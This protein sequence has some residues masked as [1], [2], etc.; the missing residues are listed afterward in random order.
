MITSAVVATIS[1]T[2]VTFNC[3]S[4]YH[5]ANSYATIAFDSSNNSA[6]VYTDVGLFTMLAQE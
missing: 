6:V 4:T 5:S 3:R 2:S 1:G